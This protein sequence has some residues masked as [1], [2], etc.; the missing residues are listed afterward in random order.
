MKYSNNRKKFSSSNLSLLIAGI[1]GMIL[2]ATF[3]LFKAGD[4]NFGIHQLAGFVVSAIIAAAGLQKISLLKTRIWGSFLLMVYLA[5]I[6]FMGLR[7]GKYRVH[8]SR[9]M[10]QD[11]GFFF[12]DVVINFFGFIPLGYL[13]ISYFLSSHHIKKEGH[14]ICLTIA[15]CI[16]ISLLIELLQYYIPGRSSSPIDL[17]FNGF[18]A[19]V[20]IT[21][22]LFE[23]RH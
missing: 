2:S 13:M 4:P 1:S 6:L 10:L 18:G 22:Y 12:P 7:P 8:T 15:V 11:M 17:L 14:L 5:G 16:S 3:D 20:G 19:F 21:Y 9:G 23:N